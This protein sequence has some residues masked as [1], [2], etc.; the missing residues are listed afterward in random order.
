RLLRLPGLPRRRRR[1]PVLVALAPRRLTPA[2]RRARRTQ[3][4]VTM[5]ALRT[6]L[7][8]SGLSL[9]AFCCSRTPR[10]SLPLPRLGLQEHFHPGSVRRGSSRWVAGGSLGVGL[11]AL[12][13]RD[14]AVVV[15]QRVQ[16]AVA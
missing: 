4:K 7:V 6:P 1:R 5:L 14:V 12:A 11:Q 9:A 8:P 10:P 2:S 16:V 13:H 15:P 3:H